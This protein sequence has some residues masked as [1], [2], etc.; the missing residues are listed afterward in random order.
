MQIPS[1]RVNAAGTFHRAVYRFLISRSP[2]LLVANFV[3]DASA[4]W[5]VLALE[6]A[7]DEL[8]S[9]RL[10]RNNPCGP[11]TCVLYASASYRRRQDY[12]R[13]EDENPSDNADD[14][15]HGF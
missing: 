15:D 8:R 9:S 3:F 2:K 5:L 4:A 14:Q 1:G 12:K 7:L 6:L 10:I 13:D 11:R